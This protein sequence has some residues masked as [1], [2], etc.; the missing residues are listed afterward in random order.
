VTSAGV[1][2]LTYERAGD[3]QVGS[4]ALDQVD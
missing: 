4:I 2:I 1:V 3:V